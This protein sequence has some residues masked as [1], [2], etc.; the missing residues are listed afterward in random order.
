[1]SA[2][3]HVQRP[4]FPMP[5]PKIGEHTRGEWLDKGTKGRAMVRIALGIH[6][7]E[8][9]VPGLKLHPDASR[10]VDDRTTE[11]R[12]GSCVY[13][14]SVGW[15]NRSYRKCAYGSPDPA[16]TLEGASRAAHSEAS[17]LRL[18]WPACTTYEP[19]PTEGETG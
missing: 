6:P 15:H 7:L 5:D 1:M 17:D 14:V 12:C 2:A 19:Q 11:P 4:L 16:M 3:Q 9:I 13:A 18:W 8:A 10:D